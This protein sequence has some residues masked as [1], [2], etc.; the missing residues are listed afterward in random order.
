MK[1][2]SAL[3]ILGASSASAASLQADEIT[4]FVSSTGTAVQI[5]HLTNTKLKLE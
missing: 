1:L 2:A 5:K 4:H 3:F